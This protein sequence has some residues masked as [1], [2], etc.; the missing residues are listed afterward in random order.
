ML[1]SYIK[2]SFILLM[3]MSVL[4]IVGLI[5]LLLIQHFLH[6]AKL[7]PVYFN[8]NH[9]SRYELEIFNSFPLLLVK[10]IGY[11]KA[12]VFPNTMRRKFKENIIK[13]NDEP[14]IFYLAWLTM[15]IIFICSI[16]LLNTAFSAILYYSYN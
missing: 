8:I 15:I 4:T 1:D 6:K 2:L 11:I 7:D 12:I 16:I 13:P 3:A 10:T 14:A 9:Y 5:P